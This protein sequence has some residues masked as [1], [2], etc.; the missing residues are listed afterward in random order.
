MVGSRSV[1][2]I[3]TAS[4][5]I[6]E[7]LAVIGSSDLAF[8]P[9]ELQ[10][11][12]SQY[13]QINLTE[14][15]T[16]RIIEESEGWIV[17]ILLALRSESSTIEI[18]KILGAREQ[19]YH[20]LANDVVSTLPDY[21]N[22]FMFATSIVEEFT[23]SFADHLLEI[24]N[25]E[26]IIQELGELNLF[27]SDT[28][29]NGEVVYRYH[30][31]FSDF[32]KKH[33]LEKLSDRYQLFQLRAASWYEQTDETEKA[34]FHHMQAQ[35]IQRAAEVIDQNAHRYYLS[36]QINLLRKWYQ[37]LVEHSDFRSLAPILLLDLAKTEITQG[38]FS[39]G[40]ELLDIAEEVLLER[41][42]FGNY[43]NL[44]VT[45]GMLFRFTGRF[46]D[47]LETAEQA[48]NLVVEYKL[49]K[50]YWD[51]AER[52]KGLVSYYLG[53]I[54]DAFRYLENAAKAFREAIN[55]N[56]D[57][58][59]IHDL[60]MTLADIGF[61]GIN[62]GRILEAQKSFREAVDLTQKIR[63]NYVD[64]A[65]ANNNYAYLNYLIGEYVEAWRAYTLALEAAKTFQLEKQMVSIMNG[66]ADV[67][68]DIREYDQAR[69]IY[70]QALDIAEKLGEN[71]SMIASYSGLVDVETSTG[72]FHKALY[73]IREIARVK[74][75]D[76]STADHQVRF[77]KV[78]RAMGQLDLARESFENAICEW[79][80]QPSPNQVVVDGYFNFACILY[81]TGEKEK[82]LDYLKRACSLVASLGY[83]QFMVIL[84]G[85]N[86]SFLTWASDQWDSPQ[87]RSLIKR[88]SAKPISRDQ[89]EKPPEEPKQVETSIQVAGFG[90]GIVRL[91][92]EVIRTT[93]WHSVGARAMFFFILE[94]KEVTKEEIALE[95]WPDFSPGKVN[96]N[97]H[98][99]LW[100]VRNALGGKHMIQFKGNTYML[101]PE[102]NLHYDVIQFEGLLVR[103]RNDLS[104]IERRA[105]LR[106]IVELYQGDFLVKID[107]TWADQKRGELLNDFL[108]ALSQ[109]AKIETE[110][111][112]FHEALEMYEKLIS[113]D[114]YQD[115]FHL[116]KIQN[117]VGL[118]NVNG[119]RRHYASY[120]E[121]LTKEL[122]IEPDQEIT[123]YFNSL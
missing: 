93:K 46:Q 101:N 117:L 96:S 83:D 9:D 112:N 72:F 67:L 79:R 66:Q 88:A 98:A 54:E 32:L 50:Y 116:G 70:Q 97:F 21:M 51:Q 73:F 94:R 115:S 85:N 10:N 80:D 61:F 30:Q 78:Y 119:A 95:F 48:Q 58:D 89:L 39:A 38:E 81:L 11:L 47:A 92:G 104:D 60:I 27:L 25:S 45:R 20:Y 84:A 41:E 49:K 31:L 6:Q 111:G 23:P 86:E 40:S 114:P 76:A 24:D 53:N 120:L 87:L 1:Y 100:R 4:L 106:Q 65:M 29:N 82:A 22:E 26:D 37:F 90:G 69:E 121:L 107:M 59:P 16:K 43:V 35:K 113:R 52:L 18:P 122:G 63:G 103:L 3:P 55:V 8:K 68:R 17:A 102:V 108:H 118:D 91:D 74:N 14:Q 105:L 99:T 71:Q 57:K 56:L 75:E 2:G 44:L 36:G 123:D 15:Q 64:I 19:I 5:Y 33:F 12:C 7:Q 110:R 13:Y 28:E 34:V 77:G 62:T 109:L 42:D